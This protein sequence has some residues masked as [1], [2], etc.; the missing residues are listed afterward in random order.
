MLN[1]Y[2]SDWVENRDIEY[3]PGLWSVFTGWDSFDVT[4][5]MV[6]LDLWSTSLDAGDPIKQNKKPKPELL[7]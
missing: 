5:G 3:F 6:V 7:G 2:N 1:F 4:Q